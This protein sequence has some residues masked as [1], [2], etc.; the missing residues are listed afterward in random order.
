MHAVFFTSW[1]Y[2]ARP[3]KPPLKQK[4]VFEISYQQ[5][6]PQKQPAQPRR[7]SD[8]PLPKDM[9]KEINEMKPTQHPLPNSNAIETFI[10]DQIAKSKESFAL[11]KKPFLKEEE[12]TK[13]S[14][15][16]PNIPGEIFKS[17][18]YKSYY[19]IVREKIRK[20]AYQNYKQLEEGEVFLTFCLNPDGLLLEAEI[21]DKKS[22]KNEYLRSIALKSVKNA[23][24]YPRFTEKLKN[25]EKLSFNVIIS[26]E[27]K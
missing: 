5:S 1:P 9:I 26:F 15:T 19:H 17:P 12:T 8:Q 20:L 23:A 14:V 27:L 18:D 25:Q 7:I 13:K 2:R 4:K 16:L 11:V 10:K 24:P 3:D 6:L 22:V 21:N